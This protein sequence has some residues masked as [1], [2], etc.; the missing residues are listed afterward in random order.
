MTTSTEMLLRSERLILHARVGTLEDLLR[1]IVDN[2]SPSG[3]V[4]FGTKNMLV[5]ETLIDEA[6]KLL[7]AD[8]EGCK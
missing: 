1:K 8:G 7:K 2:A 4:S 6:R 3:V 5:S